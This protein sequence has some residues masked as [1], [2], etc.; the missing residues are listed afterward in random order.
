MRKWQRE[1]W[2]F[3]EIVEILD[4]CDTIRLGLKGMGE[5]PY[6]VPLSFGY[7]VKNGR[8]Y[9]YFHCA[10]SGCKIDLINDNCNVCVEADVLNGYS[11]TEHGITADYESVIAFGKAW[12]VI[13]ADAVHGIKL[14]LDHCGVTGY[15]PEACV[16]M[17]TVAVYRITVE[18][19]TGKKRFK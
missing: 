16:K 1:V 19:I 15:D 10:Q 11:K 9:I 8:L 6:V 17:G 2:D 18:N 12:R 5:Y 4:K 3:N 7:E 14:L 13:G